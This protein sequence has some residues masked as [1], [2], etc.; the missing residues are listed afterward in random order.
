MK[1]RSLFTALAM[2]LLLNSSAFALIENGIE[3]ENREST[4]PHGSVD[5]GQIIDNGVEGEN[6]EWGRD[7]TDGSNGFVDAIIHGL[8]YVL[9]V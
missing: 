7:L 8:L 6:R 9:R 4:T 1:A 3:G 5:P 2:A